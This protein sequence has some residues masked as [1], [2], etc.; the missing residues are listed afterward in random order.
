[1]D[2]LTPSVISPWGTQM[3]ALPSAK[4][5]KAIASSTKEKRDRREFPMPVP[6][7]LKKPA[8][9][10]LQTTFS[11]PDVGRGQFRSPPSTLAL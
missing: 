5:I 7:S 11:L 6:S 10:G 3:G 4:K 8:I 9:A 2:D 1:M